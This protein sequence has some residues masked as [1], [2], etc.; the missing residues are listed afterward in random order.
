MQK[1]PAFIERLLGIESGRGEGAIWSLENSWTWAP[2]ISLLLVALSI[3]WVW[4]FYAS[5]PVTAGRAAK[6][7]LGLLRL[8]VIGLLVFMIAE[9]VITLRRTGLPYVVVVVDDSASMGV[10]DLPAKKRFGRKLTERIHSAGFDE[11]NRL[12][13]AKTL[14]VED[15]ARMLQTIAKKYKLKVYFLAGSAR[16]QAGDVDQ[17]AEKIRL[18]SAEGTSSRLGDGLRA[19][20]ADLRGTPPAAVIVLTDGITTDGESL[21]QA[22]AYARR[23]GVPLLT[24]GL[25]SED[26][27]IDIE[28]S[29]L[30]VDEFVFVDDVVTFEASLTG[31]GMEGRE[32]PV[33]L[34]EKGKKKIL[35]KKSVTLGKDGEPI[36]LRLRYRPREVGEFQYVVEVKPLRDEAKSDNNREE[37][38]VQVRKEKVRVLLVQAYP[39]HEFHY[40]KNLLQRDSTIELSTLLQ[41]ADLEYAQIEQSALRVF[42]VRRE[43]LFHYDV[44]VLADLNP[45]FLSAST[46]QNIQ[47]F[48]VEKGGGIVLIAGPRF[49]PWD[50]RDTP[51][52]MLMPIELD[53]SRRPDSAEVYSEP[54]LLRPTKLGLIGS[55]MQLGDTSKETAKLWAGLPPLYWYLDTPRVKPAARVLAVHPT[56]E[57]SDGGKLPL[58]MSQFVGAGKILFHGI[59][60]TWRWR[61]RMGDVLLARYWVQS[62]RSL[63]RAK[64][65][66]GESRAEL[67]V[68][69]R[70]YQQG[71][72]VRIRVRFVDER[73]APVS[74]EGVTVILDQEGRRTRRL[75]LRRTPTSRGVFEGVFTESGEGKYDI[76]MASPSTEGRAPSA[77]FLVVSPPGEFQRIAMDAS[78]LARAAKTS[79]GKFYTIRSADRLIQELPHGRQV[80]VETLPPQVLWDRWWVLLL[81]LTLITAEWIGRKR[82]SLL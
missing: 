46:M 2:W 78:E 37:R 73:R 57:R 32:V 15:E 66:G 41:E 80:P 31:S 69:R 14:L 24:I 60:E 23:K 76:W 40:L 1:I 61:F 58:V 7:F 38:V 21:S 29:E 77:S 3:G 56:H 74:D 39:N 65:L 64:L 54:F 20:L 34:R 82:V 8:A 49:L 70:E 16:P 12:N 17:I 4:Y 30:L 55:A 42:P 51:L 63:A 67:S 27:P 59:D 81:F 6:T 10:S 45:S 28:L 5:E 48:V 35:A 68:D 50:F 33:T 53:D 47:D 71:E 26:P 11:L 44:L 19:V 62:I 52:A 25:G 72:P 79:R 13:M 36:K 75:K 18:A 9:F 22:A 43:E